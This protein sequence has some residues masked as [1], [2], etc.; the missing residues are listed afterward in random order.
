MEWLPA[1]AD[2]DADPAADAD[3][4]FCAANCFERPMRFGSRA[5][6]SLTL[7]LMYSLE[8]GSQSHAGCW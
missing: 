1:L 6:C 8:L 5:T 3:A 7:M 4:D 2:P